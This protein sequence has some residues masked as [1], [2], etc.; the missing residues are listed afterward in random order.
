MVNEKKNEKVT[1]LPKTATLHI[2]LKKAVVPIGDKPASSCTKE[3]FT[4]VV[5]ITRSSLVSRSNL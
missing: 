4:P 3:A 1:Y 2:V 5:G